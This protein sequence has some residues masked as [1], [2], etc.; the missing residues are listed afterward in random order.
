MST[1]GNSGKVFADPWGGGQ[2]DESASTEPAVCLAEELTASIC[3]IST[4]QFN[5]VLITSQTD[6]GHGFYSHHASAP[7]QGPEAG[8]VT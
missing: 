3:R 7:A 4:I 8:L 6:P 5:T 2:A 1:A